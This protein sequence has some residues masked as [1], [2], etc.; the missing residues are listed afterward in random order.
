MTLV[1][2]NVLIDVLS[3]DPLW[4]PWSVDMLAQRFDLGALIVTDAT[5]AELSPQFASSRSL[6]AAMIELNVV[7]ERIP[8]EALFIAGGTFARYRSHGGVR[9]NVLADFFIG[10][11]AQVLGCP[12]LTRD[13]RRYRR[14]FPGVALI[15]PD[16]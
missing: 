10:A 9:T 12:V 15:A 6:D 1:D 4:R 13:V 8:R 5:Y 14:Y 2:T 7:L 11:H 3:N 16:G